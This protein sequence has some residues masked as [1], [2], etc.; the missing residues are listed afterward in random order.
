MYVFKNESK[1]KNYNIHEL[2]GDAC[3]LI[4]KYGIEKETSDN[5]SCIIVEFEGLEKFLKN[6]SIKEK[7][8]SNLNDFEKTVQ[9]ASSIK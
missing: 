7:V 3:D 2:T 9:R 4:I 1:Q 6:E 8:N 5:L